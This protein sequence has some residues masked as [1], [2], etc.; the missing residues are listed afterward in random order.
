MV[1]IFLLMYAHFLK[2]KKTSMKERMIT[3]KA[4]NTLHVVGVISL[5]ILDIARTVVGALTA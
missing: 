4:R 3:W 2:A 5:V 1:S